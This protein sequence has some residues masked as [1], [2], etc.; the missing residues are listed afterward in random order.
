MKFSEFPYKRP[1]YEKVMSEITALTEKFKAATSAKEQLS[2]MKELEQIEIETFTA[3]TI[4]NI[5]YTV[6]TRDKFYS[7]EHEYNEQMGPVLSEKLQD[8]NKALVASPYRKEIEAEYSPL[9]FKNI[10]ISLKSFSPE[11]IPLI[12]EENQLIQQYQKLR[13]RK[14]RI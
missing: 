1:D 13:F 2:I 10:E 12:Q 14:N 8:F 7:D 9:M 6:D 3:S 4:C 5:R 11:L